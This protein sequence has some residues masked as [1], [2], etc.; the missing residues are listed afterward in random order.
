MSPRVGEDL[1]KPGRIGPRV[2]GIAVVAAG[3][4]GR[5]PAHQGGQGVRASTVED[6]LR[7]G[8]SG[9]GDDA[10]GDVLHGTDVK[11]VMDD[12]GEVVPDEVVEV[13][14]AA[15]VLSSD[16]RLG[17]G[18]AVGRAPVRERPECRRAGNGGR[19]P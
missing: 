14:G 12:G 8:A 17:A 1:P 7:G 13:G 10:G 15:L 18:A 9:R 11:G 2:A 16:P 4:L 6:V 3:E 19:L 5:L